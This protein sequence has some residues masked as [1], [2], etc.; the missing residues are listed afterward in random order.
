MT[1]ENHSVVFFGHVS[2][3]YKCTR[4]LAPV[5]YTRTPGFSC[6]FLPAETP[7]PF[8]VNENTTELV[9][10][11]SLDRE[12]I[13]RYRLLLICRVQTGKRTTDV[14]TSLDVLVN[15]EDDNAPYVNGTDT[16]DIVIS[17][18]RT[19]VRGCVSH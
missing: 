19:K 6:G 18:N 12:E 14:G 3:A 10:T 5:V 17:L 1:S 9:V 8:A 7:A 16:A 2:T 4:L 15:D 13:E 11:A